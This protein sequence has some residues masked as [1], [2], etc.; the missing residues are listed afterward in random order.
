MSSSDRRCY[1][2]AAVATLASLGWVQV[3]EG[4]EQ[5]ERYTVMRKASA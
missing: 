4:V 1:T 2:A 5:G 3:S